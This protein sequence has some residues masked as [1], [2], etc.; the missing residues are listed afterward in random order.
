MEEEEGNGSRV[1]TAALLYISTAAREATLSAVVQ[2]VELHYNMMLSQNFVRNPSFSTTLV[3]PIPCPPDCAATALRFLT[4]VDNQG[5][6][7][8]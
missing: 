3:A 5:E 4:A 2:G 7:V 6:V 1:E 8:P